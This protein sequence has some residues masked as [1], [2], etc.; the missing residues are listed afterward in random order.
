MRFQIKFRLEGKRQVLPLNYQ[1]PLSSWIYK[2]LQKGDAGL[3]DFLH[4]EGY[5]LENGK[6]F[7]LFR[8]CTFPTEPIK[9]F[10]KPTGWNYGRATPGLP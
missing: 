6:T 10:P 3:S 7:K 8:N 4:R 2:V 9:L 5:R 1:Y